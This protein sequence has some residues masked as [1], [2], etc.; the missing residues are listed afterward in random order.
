M[1]HRAQWPEA[2]LSNLLI[3][4]LILTS[5]VFGMLIKACTSCV[6][7]VFIVPEGLVAETKGLFS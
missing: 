2:F 3:D 6:A 4:K 7:D 1:S 5:V